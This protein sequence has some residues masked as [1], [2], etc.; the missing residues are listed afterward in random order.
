MIVKCGQA[1]YLGGVF[2]KDL[3]GGSGGSFLD[4]YLWK[5][6][7]KEALT[8]GKCGLQS[9]R[10]GFSSAPPSACDL[11]PREGVTGNISRDTTLYTSFILQLHPALEKKLSVSRWVADSISNKPGVKNLF[12]TCKIREKKRGERI[13]TQKRPQALKRQFK[14]LK[15][16][17]VNWSLTGRREPTYLGMGHR[18]T[19]LPLQRSVYISLGFFK[20]PF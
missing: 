7:D 4:L 19:G 3:G 6:W 8:R 10:E 11:R 1:L 15:S 18:Q 5:G 9:I 16:R 14:L 17:T 13:P 2:Q 12:S 20:A